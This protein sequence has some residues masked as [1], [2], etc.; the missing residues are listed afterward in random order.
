MNA[1]IKLSTK[2][3]V[4]IPKDV[5]DRFDFSAGDRLDVVERHDG[6]LLRKASTKRG[7]SIEEVTANLR[8]IVCYNGPPVS[9]EEM[10][11]AIADM[12][13]SGGPKYQ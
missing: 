1:Q 2:G 13:K 6:V 10:D 12:W 8:S 4:V 7:K 3:Q 11:E 5:R 9:I